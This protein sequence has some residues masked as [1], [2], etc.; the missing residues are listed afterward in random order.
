MAQFNTGS[1]N[2]G[3]RGGFRGDNSQ[4]GGRS[5]RNG[6]RFAQAR[7]CWCRYDS[8]YGDEDISQNARNQ[9][10][11]SNATPQASV[12]MLTTSKTAYDQN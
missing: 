9:N 11:G 6:D 7:R 8:S 5:M 2:F 1:N 10:R 3:N 12:T 4:R